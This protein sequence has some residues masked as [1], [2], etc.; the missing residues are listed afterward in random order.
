[1]VAILFYFLRE[2]MIANFNPIRFMYYGQII[3]CIGHHLFFFIKALVTT[4]KLDEK[5]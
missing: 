3:N 2:R 5:Y 4:L 1:M